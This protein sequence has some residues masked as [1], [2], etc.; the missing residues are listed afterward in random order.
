MS[1][2]AILGTRP[3]AY[4]VLGYCDVN[5]RKPRLALVAMRKAVSLDPKRWAFH[6]GLA[7]VRA[8]NGLDPKR[9]ARRAVTLYPQS[10]V[11]RLEARKLI[12]SS[13]SRWPALGYQLAQSPSTL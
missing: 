13:P 4:E 7:V 11:V 6:Y 12:R 3:E 5:A 8:S 10:S 9:A 2:I 1:S